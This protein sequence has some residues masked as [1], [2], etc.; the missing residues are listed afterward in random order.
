MKGN[1]ISDARRPE[2]P[3]GGIGQAG[4][5]SELRFVCQRAG[6]QLAIDLAREAWG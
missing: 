3:A 4:D 1:L 5:V 2:H 6:L